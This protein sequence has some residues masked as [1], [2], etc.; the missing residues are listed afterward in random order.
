MQ[1]SLPWPQEAYWSSVCVCDWIGCVSCRDAEAKT[2]ILSFAL[3]QVHAFSLKKPQL[4]SCLNHRQATFFVLLSISMMFLSM[5]IFYLSGFCFVL[6]F[7]MG[8]IEICLSYTEIN[9]CL[10]E[11]MGCFS[12]LIFGGLPAWFGLVFWDQLRL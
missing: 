4:G 6:G 11:R 10:M 5:T 8:F 3:L 12:C 2:L 1:L 7:C 9:S